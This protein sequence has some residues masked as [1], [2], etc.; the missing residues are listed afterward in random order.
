MAAILDFQHE[1]ASAMAA[2]DLEVLHIVINPCIFWNDMCICKT[3]K[4]ICT[5]GNLAAI[6]DFQHTSTSHEI[7]SN[8]TIERKF[9]PEN[10]GVAVGILSLYA[11][12]RCLG[13]HFTP[14]SLLANVAKKKGESVTWSK[15]KSQ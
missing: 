14:H 5:Y 3:S 10:I 11:Y 13:S 2:G 8:T 4:V 12:K 7:G 9:D 6:L 1:L 15:S